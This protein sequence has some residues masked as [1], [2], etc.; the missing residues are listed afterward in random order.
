VVGRAGLDL[1]LFGP[2]AL[3]DASIN[4]TALNDFSPADGEKLDL[5]AI[6]AIA[7]GGL[8]NDAFTFI[9][10]AAFSAPGQ[11]RWLD[12]GTSRAVVGSVDA[13]ADAELTIFL[14][15]PG[16]VTSSWFVL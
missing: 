4:A 16:P 3:G 8:A 15:A 14:A 12:L 13:D 11:L 9:G 1:F 2:A 6:D 7:G 10:T 5:S